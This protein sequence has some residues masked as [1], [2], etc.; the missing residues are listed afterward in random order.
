M[1][2]SGRVRQTGP[3]YTAEGAAVVTAAANSAEAVRQSAEN[4]RAGFYEGFNSR[5]DDIAKYSVTNYGAKGDGITINTTAIQAAFDAVNA[6]GGGTVYFPDGVYLTDKI[7]VYSNTK[8][9][10]RSYGSSIVRL[11]PLPS[12]SLFECSGSSSASKRDIFFENIRL[13]HVS[14]YASP[15]EIKGVLIRGIYTSSCGV[16]NCYFD[17]FGYVGIKVGNTGD[18]PYAYSN[19]WKIHSNVFLGHDGPGYSYAAVMCASKGEY[20]DV[21]NNRIINFQKAM[22]IENSANDRFVNNLVT[23]CS[24]GADVY[25]F[26]LGTNNGKT[27]IDGNTL[28]HIAG[29]AVRVRMVSSPASLASSDEYGVQITNNMIMLPAVGIGLYGGYGHIVTGN[30]IKA[31]NAQCECIHMEN[32]DASN[33]IDYCLVTGNVFQ[34]GTQ[35]ISGATGTHNSVTGNMII[36]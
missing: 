2:F 17:N 14:D 27:V 31:L 4:I 10:G 25:G 6:L 32:K 29:T 22:Y 21:S 30:K 3:F 20:I 11:V 33:I 36:P 5:L 12:G 16:K 18:Q 23:C 9:E 26:V 7:I 15:D 13:Q 28:N 34:R 1:S 19:G 35:G 24:Y 8:I